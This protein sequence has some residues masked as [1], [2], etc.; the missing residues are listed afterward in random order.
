MCQGMGCESSLLMMFEIDVS[1]HTLTSVMGRIFVYKIYTARRAACT[2]VYIQIFFVHND[3]VHNVGEPKKIYVLHK[4]T[5]ARLKKGTAQSFRLANSA[6]IF[7]D[8][9]WYDIK[10]HHGLVPYLV[11]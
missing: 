6:R 5:A 7:I 10:P 4:L 11:S 1:P 9:C 8:L 2:C 3:F